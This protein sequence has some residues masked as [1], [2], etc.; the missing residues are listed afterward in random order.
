[1]T[2]SRTELAGLDPGLQLGERRVALGVEIHDHEALEGQAL[3]DDQAG[4]AARAVRRRRAVVL[5]D[6][7]AAGDAAVVV[8]VEQAA[9]KTSPPTLSK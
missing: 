1:M 5:R 3:G 8:H 7:A 6:R 4:H 2:S 9:S